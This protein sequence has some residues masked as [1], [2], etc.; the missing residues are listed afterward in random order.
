MIKRGIL[1]IVLFFTIF[2]CQ[3]TYANNNTYKWILTPSYDYD[4]IINIDLKDDMY[5]IKYGYTPN[6]LS[7][8]SKSENI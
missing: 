1:C 5:P 8:T 3:N 6:N 2:C 7:I 4:D